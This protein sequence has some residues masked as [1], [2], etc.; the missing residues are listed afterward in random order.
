MGHSQFLRT[1]PGKI[2]VFLRCLFVPFWALC[3]RFVQICP[4]LQPYDYALVAKI[5]WGQLWELMML[6]HIPQT[7][8]GLRLWRSHPT[9]RVFV[10]HP[11]LRCPNYGHLKI[12]SHNSK[13]FRLWRQIMCNH[14]ILCDTA[15]RFRLSRSFTVVIFFSLY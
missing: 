6:P 4:S 8:D 2:T 13:E 14:I 1:C 15:Q 3:P 11:G 10:V 12:T 7:P 5:S 9:I